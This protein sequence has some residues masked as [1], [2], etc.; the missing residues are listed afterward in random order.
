MPELNKA[1][2]T[3]TKYVSK[4]DKLASGPANGANKNL[5]IDTKKKPLYTPN[6]MN[7]T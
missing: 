7:S 1:P 6:F 2:A 3:Q 5:I 4:N